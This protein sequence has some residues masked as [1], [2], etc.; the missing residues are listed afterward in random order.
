M[1]LWSSDGSFFD[2]LTRP[3]CW[4]VVDFSVTAPTFLLR[5]QILQTQG[6]LQSLRQAF[7]IAVD[8]EHIDRKLEEFLRDF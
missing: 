6:E 2:C 3:G 5:L 7:Q 4:G 8:A 1:R